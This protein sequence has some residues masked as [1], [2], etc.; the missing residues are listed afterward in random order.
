MEGTSRTVKPCNVTARQLHEK[1]NQQKKPTQKPKQTNKT[2]S[3][4][5]TK[6][7]S[8]CRR[9]DYQATAEFTLSVFLR[10]TSMNTASEKVTNFQNCKVVKIMYFC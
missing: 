8:I 4:K 9:P 1:S 2:Q 3:T 5:N 7:T 10:I 6:H